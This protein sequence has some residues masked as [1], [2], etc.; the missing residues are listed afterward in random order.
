MKQHNWFSHVKAYTERLV[1]LR[2]IS[3]S[4]EENIVANEVLALLHEEGMSAFYT[5][6]GL[7]PIANDPYG[8][9]NVYAFLRGQ[10]TE[11]LILLGHFDT[12]DTADYGDLEP[13]ALNPAALAEHIDT[14]LAPGTRLDGEAG[15]WL[16]GRGAADM[17]SGVALNIV[18]MRALAERTRT[19]PLPFSILL[20][21]TPDEEN[22]SAGVLQAVRFLLRWREERQLRYLGVINTDYATALYPGDPHRYIYGGTVGKLLPSFLCIG[23]ES[24]AGAPFDGLDAN[25]LA[26][27]LIRDLSMNDELS[28][29]GK[30]QVTVP[31]V[32]L[33]STDLKQQYDVQLPFAAY[34]Y[35]NVLT[36][37]SSPE[38]LLQRLRLRSEIVMKQLLQRLAAIERRWRQASGL[39]NEI[40]ERQ[41]N[42]LSY[43]E[44][45]AETVQHLGE[46]RVQSELERT[47]QS[48]PSRL[49]KRERSLQLVRRL[50]S[51]S[52]RRGPAVVIYYS[53]PYYPH[54]P[55]SEGLLAEAIR[56]VVTVHPEHKLMQREFFPLLSDLSYLQLDPAMDVTALTSNMPIWQED[57]KAPKPG[58]YRLPLSLMQQL[59]LPV[60]N[61]GVHGRGAHQRD[62][63]VQ[64]PYSFGILPQLLY[65]VMEVLARRL[66]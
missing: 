51:L 64:M 19:E 16:F 61:W 46:E 50:W 45:Y 4:E 12:V 48:L 8:R 30:G 1:A 54:V 25:L 60:F 27:E 43:A 52:R 44:L 22:E 31:P 15:D 63:A 18:L 2:G 49:D 13:L 56:E 28:D 38:Q 66:Q 5:D 47:W 53:P 33:H 3:P 40:E 26:A 41:G 23:R 7:D 32:T 39:P 29:S 17:K 11:T 37:S 10:R 24:H 65:E 9:K 42:V 14:L 36:L 20:L 59:Q 21:A 57:E 55:E 6:S 62:E 58:G 35:L 34:F